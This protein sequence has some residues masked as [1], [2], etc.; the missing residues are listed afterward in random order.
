MNS[1]LPMVEIGLNRLANCYLYN[2]C[3]YIYI[4]VIANGLCIPKYAWIVEG[5][6][7][8]DSGEVLDNI[9]KAKID[10]KCI[11]KW[12]FRVVLH[13]YVLLIFTN[14]LYDVKAYI[15]N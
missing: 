5:V 12:A 7:G 6:T 3:I 8:N 2:L 1:K 13:S 11:F 15:L 9:Q 14:K 4:H 10:S